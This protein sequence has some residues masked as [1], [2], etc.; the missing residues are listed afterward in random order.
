MTRVFDA[1]EGSP[2][3]SEETSGIVDALLHHISKL[4]NVPSFSLIDK[5]QVLIAYVDKPVQ[6]DR[7]FY[8]KIDAVAMTPTGGVASI[9][10][11]LLSNTRSASEIVAYARNL[12]TAYTEE[13]CNSFGSNIYFFDQKSRTDNN[14]PMPVM[15]GG[16]EQSKIDALLTHKRMLISTAPKQLGFTMT[17][18]HSNKS[19]S[20]IYGEEVRL[21]EQRV[22]FFLENREWYDRKGIPW[23]LGLLLSGVAGAGKTSAIRAIANMTK[24]HIVNVNFANIATATQLNTLFFNDKLQVFSDS[25]LGQS[26]SC[27]IP[28]QDRLYVLE[29]IDTLGAIVARRKPGQAAIA[30]VND[31]LTLGTILTVL[32]G[33]METPGRILIMTSNH[34]EMLDPALIRP[35]RVDVQVH[36]DNATKETIA[37][38]YEG[39]FDRPLSPSATARLPDRALSP[40]EVG[41]VLFRNFG[42]VGDEDNIVRDIEMMAKTKAAETDHKQSTC[43]SG[44]ST[45][46]NR[47]A[48][49]QS[50][51]IA[52]IVPIY[53][54]ELDS[55]ITLAVKADSEI[56]AYCQYGPSVID[57][58][59]RVLIGKNVPPA[60]LATGEVVCK[61]TPAAFEAGDFAPIL[62]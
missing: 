37:E 49:D 45:P 35:G 39:F 42:S 7:D 5:G 61:D 40:A 57:N 25:S 28:V 16:S 17:P 8:V 50:T 14:P 32:D 27:Y 47:G 33:T 12:Y 54:S 53:A 24:R 13:I 18:F 56:G 38:M 1:D 22:K 48:P 21:I 43:T 51:A 19:F 34:P 11:S 59:P 31:E 55:E 29:E 26:T 20:N 36:F 52:D 60:W 41:Q 15:N 3:M 23:Q 2:T 44:A 30:T 58:K 10:L 6:L 9:S 62:T 4:S 46:T